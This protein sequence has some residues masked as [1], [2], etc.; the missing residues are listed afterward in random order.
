MEEFGNIFGSDLQAVTGDVHQ[1]EEV[2][3]RVDGLRSPFEDIVFDPFDFYKISSWKMIMQ[4][5]HT[6]VEVSRVFFR[7][8]VSG[9]PCS[10]YSLRFFGVM[11]VPSAVAD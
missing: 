10:V 4:D 7:L 3:C 6:S 5:F 1:I 8:R 9:H 11:N 2:L